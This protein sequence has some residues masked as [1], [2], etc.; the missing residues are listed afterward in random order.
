MKCVAPEKPE[1]R[2][3][4]RK[5]LDQLKKSY[6]KKKDGRTDAK[7]QPN[8]NLCNIYVLYCVRKLGVVSGKNI[9][10]SIL[11]H[12]FLILNISI[13]R[14]TRSTSASIHFKIVSLK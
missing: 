4:A 2:E 6:G 13:S 10:F 8:V 11:S 9:F 7:L 12:K 1:F 3:I 14:P 5:A